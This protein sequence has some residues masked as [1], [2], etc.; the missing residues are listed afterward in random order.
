MPERPEISTH[1]YD[2]H[3]VTDK[4]SDDLYTLQSESV[5]LDG[6]LGRW[7]TVYRTSVLVA[8]NGQIEG[9]PLNSERRPD[10]TG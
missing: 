8:E 2:T 9:G 4:T 10:R 6:Y 1:L 3:A 5:E 7:V